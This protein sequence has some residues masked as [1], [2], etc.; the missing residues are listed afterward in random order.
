MAKTRLKTL[1]LLIAF[2]LLFN[3]ILPIMSNA[4]EDTTIG[5]YNA[6]GEDEPILVKEGDTFSVNVD[7]RNPIDEAHALTGLVEFDTSKLEIVNM[8]PYGEESY[9]I[10]GIGKLGTTI[11]MSEWHEGSDNIAFAHTSDFGNI[12]EGTS[13]TIEFRVKDGATGTFDIS[14]QNVV[15]ADARTAQEVE[16]PIT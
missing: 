10:T 12:R 2:I 13:M 14:L 6:A 15:Y 1:A 7:F 3:M 16:Y 11:N 9:V 4:A 8:E 5:L